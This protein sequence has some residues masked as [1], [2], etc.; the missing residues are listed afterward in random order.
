MNTTKILIKAI[1]TSFILFVLPSHAAADISGTWKHSDKPA[2][3]H[4][5]VQT[6]RITVKSHDDNEDAAGLT[7]IKNLSKTAQSE[8]VWT[9]EM[10]NGYTNNYVQVK[11]TSSEPK[12]LVIHDEKGVKVLTLIRQ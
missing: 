2:L 1:V 12:I 10:Y 11:I 4:V 6:G 8:N 7:V 3:L 5:D 9:G